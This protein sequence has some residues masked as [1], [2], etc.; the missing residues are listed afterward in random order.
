MGLV[1][2]ISS[3]C[4]YCLIIYTIDALSSS[5]TMEGPRSAFPTSS[6]TTMHSSTSSSDQ[7]AAHSRNVDSEDSRSSRVVPEIVGVVGGSGKSSNGDPAGGRGAAS[8]DGQPHHQLT[9]SKRRT[10]LNISPPPQDLFDD[11]H[12]SC[13]D[14]PA[15]LDS[16]QSNSIWMEDS[17][18][19]FSNMSTSSYND[20]TEV[21]RKARKRTPRQKPGPKA[22]RTVDAS[23]DVFDADSAKAPHFV[24][25]QLGPES[26]T[27]TKTRLVVSSESHNLTYVVMKISTLALLDFMRLDEL[28]IRCIIICLSMFSI[29][30]FVGSPFIIRE[31]Q[32]SFMTKLKES[33]TKSTTSTQYTCKRRRSGQMRVIFC[34]RQN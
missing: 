8:Q 22:V 21:P 19:N 9:P 31:L 1:P 12:M 33:P 29:G 11:S 32:K 5:L 18:S 24:L 23:M 25:S 6:S 27:S 7:N 15:P 10:I 14:A 28:K 4:I 16:E 13:Q 2:Y 34:Y 17:I 20:N 3:A 26:K 30:D